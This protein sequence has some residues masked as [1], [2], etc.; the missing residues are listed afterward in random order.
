MLVIKCPMM[1]HDV[2]NFLV[3]S[4]TA[5]A[6]NGVVVLRPGLE[7]LN[8]VPADEEIKVVQ[9][10][11]A[12]QDVVQVPAET[13]Q[14]AM[15]YITALHDCGTCKHET[16]GTACLASACDCGACTVAGCVCR[17]CHNGSAWEWRHGN[18]NA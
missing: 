9:Q 8:E 11:A 3:E 7:L 1:T 15:D 16:D 17:T 5:Q 6:K 13:W 12:G 18:G 4:L 10:I 2:Y 14:A